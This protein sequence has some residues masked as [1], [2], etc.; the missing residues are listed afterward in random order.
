MRGIKINK[1]EK[2]N[3]FIKFELRYTL[4]IVFSLFI[5]NEL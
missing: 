2:K 1:F 4:F 5:I 3:Y